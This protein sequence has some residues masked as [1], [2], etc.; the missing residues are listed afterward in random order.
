[1]REDW[2]FPEDKRFVPTSKGGGVTAPTRT[3]AAPVRWSVRV[4]RRVAYPGVTV[5]DPCVPTP[6]RC[7]RGGSAHCKLICFEGDVVGCSRKMSASQGTDPPSYPARV[8]RH[9]AERKHA[10]TACVSDESGYQAELHR[11]LRRVTSDP[12]RGLATKILTLRAVLEAGLCDAGTAGE[13]KNTCF[14]RRVA[15]DG[16][17]D[18]VCVGTATLPPGEQCSVTAQPVSEKSTSDV[19][20][21]M[22]WH[23]QPGADPWAFS[24]D[25]DTAVLKEL[26]FLTK[27]SREMTARAARAMEAQAQHSD[28]VFGPFCIGKQSWRSF[29]K[30]AE[31]VVELGKVSEKYILETEKEKDAT[32][33]SCGKQ[34]DEHVLRREELTQ[35]KSTPPVSS[36][37]A[38]LLRANAAVRDVTNFAKAL[39]TRYP[40]PKLFGA[41]DRDGDETSTEATEIGFEF[42]TRVNDASKTRAIASWD[43]DDPADPDNVTFVSVHWS[44]IRMRG[45]GFG[46]RD[47]RTDMDVRNTKRNET[48]ETTKRDD[49]SE[50]GEVVAGE[51]ARIETAGDPSPPAAPIPT[52]TKHEKEKEAPTEAEAPNDDV[53]LSEPVVDESSL[54]ASLVNDCVENVLAREKEKQREPPVDPVASLVHRAVENV[55]ALNALTPRKPRSRAL[56][57]G[58]NYYNPVC[59]ELTQ[60]RG[61]LNDVAAV[62]AA[63]QSVGFED[64]DIKILID[65]PQEG[66][67]SFFGRSLTSPVSPGKGKG[68]QSWRD[69]SG[70]PP[71]FASLLG[72]TNTP[73][74]E[75][76]KKQ[77]K[78]LTNE[79]VAGDVLL[80][81]F[82][83][84]CCAF[85]K[86]RHTVEARSRVTECSYTRSYKTDTFRSQ[87]QDTP[88]K[89]LTKRTVN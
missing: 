21:E 6:R 50:N 78:W 66:G 77:L 31:R 23:K 69:G 58:C 82:S 38:S 22:Q 32:K 20:E 19:F 62:A 15:R 12:A 57:V 11:V 26:R 70:L 55:I 35:H 17:K 13:Y 67:S 34:P 7:E 49:E 45:T 2:Q 16:S 54:V 56:L 33:E 41:T 46:M 24:L 37:R 72:I 27:K 89:C 73:T 53:P 25:E 68:N 1:M 30:H 65:T 48:N 10:V 86:S 75:N 51:T 71:H 85:T 59:R 29:G 60:L 79:A 4:A 76:I 44:D 42:G 14:A 64:D 81:H 5:W 39:E 18:D 74:T 36:S 83:G 3:R 40:W 28:D 52:P 88:R 43:D 84:T 61:A 9:L 47:T 87:S 80:L 63:L 8:V